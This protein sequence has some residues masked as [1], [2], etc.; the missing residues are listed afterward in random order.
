MVEQSP[1]EALVSPSRTE[2][3]CRYYQRAIRDYVSESMGQR[4]SFPVAIEELRP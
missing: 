4:P 2:Q 3:G 1:D